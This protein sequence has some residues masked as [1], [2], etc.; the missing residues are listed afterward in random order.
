M[1]LAQDIDKLRVAIDAQRAD[2]QTLQ[3]KVDA[4]VET[5]NKMAGTTQ[6]M[7]GH[8]DFVETTY[9]TLK[10]PLDYISNRFGTLQGSSTTPALDFHE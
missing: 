2:I 6:R 5:V 10:A 8:I 4:L 1:E 9:N 3:A 7:D